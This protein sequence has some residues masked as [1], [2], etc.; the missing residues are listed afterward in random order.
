MPTG[1]IRM[2]L[3]ITLSRGDEQV[4]T[5]CD[6]RD[7]EIPAQG[8]EAFR[9]AAQKVLTEYVFIDETDPGAAAVLARISDVLSVV[10]VE[11]AAAERVG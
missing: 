4:F 6:T 3:T 2:T 8:P 10:W 11:P 1:P 5:S 9:S 7:L